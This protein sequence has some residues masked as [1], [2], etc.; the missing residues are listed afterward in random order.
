MKKEV[1]NETVLDVK[2]ELLYSIIRIRKSYMLVSSSMQLH[3]VEMLILRNVYEMN[4]GRKGGVYVSDILGR[5]HI[6]KPALSQI[7]NALERKKLIKRKLSESDHRKVE[8]RVTKKGESELAA[9][10]EPMNEYLNEIINR[11]GEE[12]VEEM[13]NL[14]NNFV[15]ISDDIGTR[16]E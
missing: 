11:M 6:S 5:V 9:S 14:I 4:L 2:D 7:L 16:E 3:I 10:L 12:N 1:V 8:V 13:I 15:D